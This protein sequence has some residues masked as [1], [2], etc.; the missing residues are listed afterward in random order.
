MKAIRIFILTITVFVSALQS[1]ADVKQ[2]FEVVYCLDLS[3]STNGL[4]EDFRNN[5]WKTVY[6]NVISKGSDVKIGVIGY[7]RP[8]FGATSA[9]VKV[10]SDITYDYDKISSALNSL[11]V[12]I[13]KGDQFIPNA[14]YVASLGMHWSEDANT[15]KI[16]YLIGNG[17]V[18]TG[19]FEIAKA[20]EIAQQNKITIKPV[21]CR[22]YNGKSVDMAGWNA[23]AKMNNVELGEVQVSQAERTYSINGINEDLLTLNKK[24]ASTFVWYGNEGQQRY[25]MMNEVDTFTMRI[26][27]QCFYSRCKVKLSNAYLSS[28]SPWD[29]TALI[30][31]HE[32][33]FASL[34]RKLLPRALQNT[35]VKTLTKF[36]QEKKDERNFLLAQMRNQLDKVK[37][38]KEFTCSVDS[39]MGLFN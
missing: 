17:M 5:F 15:K 14:L 38:S 35:D 25:K 8:S 31:Q 20:C 32:P 22:E 16:I 9:Y 21:Y 10:M 27:P 2:R 1:T 29:L 4:L 24:L 13:E 11:K 33:D 34:D 39:V 6:S 30:K 18:Q 7:A 12:N 28:L 19:K 3:G 37:F 26:S 23:I 36:L